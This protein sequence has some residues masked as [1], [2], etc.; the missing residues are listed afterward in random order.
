MRDKCDL[1]HDIFRKTAQSAYLVA[2]Q[3]PGQGTAGYYLRRGGAQ[4]KDAVYR[5][6]FFLLGD[7]QFSKSKFC[8]VW[9][10]YPV[11][12]A[13]HFV[14]AAAHAGEN[15]IPV[16]AE[17]IEKYGSGT[18]GGAAQQLLSLWRKG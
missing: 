5:P 10:D 12:T 17:D 18:V 3:F 6:F 1:C 13:E 7:E 8:P 4:R 14:G 2:V 15:G 9:T 11:G 16:C